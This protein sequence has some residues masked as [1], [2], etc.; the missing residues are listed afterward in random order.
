[1]RRKSFL[2]PLL[3]I[4]F[5]VLSFGLSLQADDGQHLNCFTVL[6]GK[7]ASADGSVLVAHNE[8]DTGDIILNIRKIAPRNYDQAIKIDLGHGGAWETTGQTNGFLWIEASAQEFADSFVNE[9][10]VVITSDA[11][12]SR[13]T[14][15]DY[16]D[17]GIGYLLRRIVAEKARTAREA[18]R[19]AGELVEKYGYRSSGRTYSIADKNEAWMLAVIRGRHWLAQRVP[20]DEVAVIPNYYTIRQVRL[21]DPD[22]FLGSPDLIDYARK[23]GWYDPEKDGP[24]DFKKAFSRPSR[25]DPV[26]DGN[27]LRM[28]RGVAILSG[29][30]W[31][32]EDDFPFSFK[33]SR[34]I[35]PEMLMSLLRDH[36]E[37]TEY[38][39][40]AGYK[41]G[42]PNLT[43][44]RT[45]C[46]SSTINSFVAVLNAQKPEPLSILLWLAPGK[47]DT[48][49]YLPIYYG[50]SRMPEGLGAGPTQHDYELFY[51]QH[52]QPE[53]LIAARDGLLHTRILR[54]ER[55]I[56]GNYGQMIEVVKKELRPLEKEYLS[57]QK[58][59]DSKFSQLQAKNPAAAGQA[60][61]KFVTEA[62]QRLEKIYK[63]LEAKY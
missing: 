38:D 15:E 2:L 57:R 28:W 42:S 3:A 24:F 22:N 20:D 36:Y 33:P 5:L 43:K 60:L 18:V 51:R 34:K 6:V 37:G 46:T 59:F 63:K 35:T 32:V 40:T 21:D 61:D 47:P 30:D 45:I 7:K 54:L 56:E 41:N 53:E 49:V 31:K 11:C 17:G 55:V 27:S 58:P 25:R 8:D 9:H 44:F 4:F 1:M 50:L 13:E 16:T 39:A 23:N 62:F 52:F 14:N 48:T 26:F 10:G 29:K 12:A 19:L